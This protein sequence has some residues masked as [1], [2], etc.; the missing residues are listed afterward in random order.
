MKL[1]QEMINKAKEVAEEA[2]W[3]YEAVGV[4]VQDVQF[5]L[6]EMDHVSKVWIDGEETDEE[7][8]GVCVTDVNSLGVNE[9]Y[10]EHMAVVA[11]NKFC[12]GEDFGEMIIKDAQVIAILAQQ[13]TM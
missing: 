8:D 9:Y 1:T 4:R 6:G 3:D 5:E 11:G 2:N 10:G 7:L 12:Y 13:W